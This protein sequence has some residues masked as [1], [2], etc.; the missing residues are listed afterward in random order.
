MTEPKKVVTRRG[1]GYKFWYTDAT[2]KR[3]SKTVYCS[4][5]KAKELMAKIEAKKSLIEAGIAP[6]PAT[7]VTLQKVVDRYL[8]NAEKSKADETIKRERK[9]FN[10][11]L[12]KHGDVPLNQITTDQI[13]DH[14]NQRLKGGVSPAGVGLEFRTIKAMFSKQV[15]KGKLIRNPALGISPPK[16]EP[17][18]IRFLTEAEVTKLLKKVDDKDF[19]DLIVGYLNTGARR[20]E[21]LSPNFT[22]DH[23]QFGLDRVKIEGKGDK[24]RYVPMNAVLRAILERRKAA[25]K[26]TPFDFSYSWTFKKLAK[27]YEAAGIENAN[28]HTLR[29]TF[30]SLLLQ[31]GEDIFRVS[32]LLGHSSVI[33]TQN[34]YADILKE[35]LAN[36]VS[37]LESIFDTDDE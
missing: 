4:L 6:A 15:K 14:I 28:V 29:K 16:V 30:G 12:A 10:P 25:G 8:E 37:R 21:I 9:V 32:K 36:S 33:V 5:K 1:V 7:K 35:D 13:E 31:Q 17:K 22:W 19:K 27:Y 26:S 20:S 18:A 34:H 23:V 2:G 3:T 11:L 24:V